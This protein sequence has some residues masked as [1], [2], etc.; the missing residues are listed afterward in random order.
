MVYLLKSF[1]FCQGVSNSIDIL[2]KARAEQE[3]V[4]SLLPLMHNERECERLKEEFSLLDDP[5]KADAIIFPA[6]GH[7]EEEA[8]RFQNKQTYDAICPF[9]KA[10]HAFLKNHQKIAWYLYGKKE[11]Q[12]CLAFLSRFPFL[13]L[14]DACRNNYP[15]LKKEN[16]TGLL[17]QS[18]IEEEPAEQVRAHFE[19]N[20]TLLSYLGPCPFYLARKKEAE[21]FLK[22]KEISRFSILILGSKSSS[23]CQAL[24]RYFQS[25]YPKAYVESINAFDDIHPEAFRRQD[26]LL[27]SSTSISKES[28]LLI[29]ERLEEV[30]SAL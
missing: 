17:V 16:R 22:D 19:K 26:F 2:K 3:K 8:R 9:L 25:K 7:T 18:T 12:E 27:I 4:C 20:S 15:S 21:E 29:K 23:N 13:S 5:E 30:T 11:H 1:G 6:H 10:R 28:V 14:I 24:K